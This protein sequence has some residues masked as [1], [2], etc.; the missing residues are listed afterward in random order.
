MEHPKKVII[1]VVNWDAK[2][3]LEECLH[4]YKKIDYS[5]YD[6]IVVDNGSKDG[7]QQMVKTLFPEFTVIELGKNYGVA[8]GQNVGI[9]HAL[10]MGFDYL[11]I[12]NN[13]VMCNEN[14]LKELLHCMESDPSIGIASPLVYYY[15]APEIIQLGGAM[16]DWDHAT[17]SLLYNGQKDTEFPACLDIDYHGFLLISHN[18][19]IRTGLYD[20]EYFAYWEDVDFCVR[21]KKLGL[22]IVC[23]KNAKVWHKVSFTTR[24]ITGFFEYYMTRNRM[25]FMK[26]YSTDARFFKF[27]FYLFSYDIGHTVYVHLVKHKSAKLLFCYF[28]G[29]LNGLILCARS[30]KYQPFKG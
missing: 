25:Y 22:R 7:S 15:D 29:F 30:V 21:V 14:M 26:K 11:F 24:R 10:E 5:N 12:S 6:V 19:I 18:T 23:L 27:Y 9:R 1:V 28:K 8:E 16:I 3:V 17:T 2:N 4:S 20:P 13:D